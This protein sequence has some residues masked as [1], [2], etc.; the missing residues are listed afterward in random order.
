MEPRFLRFYNQE[1]Q[2]LREMGGE[3]AAEFP[4][5]AGR[6]GLDSFEC[7]DPYVERLLE[8][9]S[10]LSA[11]V[12]LKLDAEFGTFTQ[13]L[14]EIAYP[15]YLS[16]TPSMLVAQFHPDPTEGSLADGYHIPRGTVLRSRLG[17]SDQTP[18]EYR[19]AHDVTLWPLRLT[20]VDYASRVKASMP[21]PPALREAEA[22]LRLR[23][24]TTGGF[25]FSKLKLRELPLFLRAGGERA[26]RLYERLFANVQ[27]VGFGKLGADSTW[28]IVDRHCLQPLGFED[29]HSLLPYGPLSF[30][31]YRLLQEYFAFPERFLFLN[32]LGLE[33]LVGKSGEDTCDI[34]VAFNQA[35]PALENVVGNQD[36][37]LFCTP[38]VNLFHRR[39]DAIHVDHHAAEHHL[40]PDRTRPLDLEVFSV[41]SVAGV[42]SGDGAQQDFRP[43]YSLTDDSTD[44]LGAYFTVRREP[45]V[46]SS[47]QVRQGPRSSYLG[48]EVY[49]SLVD[50]SSAPY[51]SDLSVLLVDTLCTNRDLPMQM[52]LG[53]GNTDFTLTIS[54]PVEGIR[55]LAGPSPPRP[56]L[57]HASGELLWRLVSHLSLNYLSIADG[58]TPQ[59]GAAALRTLLDLYCDRN[60][61]ALK[62]QI[63]GVR[64]VDCRPIVRKLPLEGP[65]VLGRGLEVTLNLDDEAFEGAGTFLFA[66][67]LERF[68]AKYTSINSF[69]ETVLRT[70]QRNEIKRWPMRIGRRHVL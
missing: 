54:A 38:A 36:F 2:F 17:K 52:P 19:T 31:G 25:P 32:L 24:Q 23:L 5:I 12:Q 57:A 21:L 69:T 41:S 42:S 45:R 44:S 29:E 1:L 56:S 47:K 33:A 40:V 15:H 27:A 39:A 58:E 8:G 70:V 51:R 6:L 62:R 22:C 3:F 65:I 9:F 14:L 11:R 48:S 55:C 26:M 37:G 4:K 34:V 16:P 35:D 68:F 18:C 20:A 63:E 61:M 67:V 30:Q 43:F 49:L 64:A 10:F 66:A 59:A 7:A 53:I 60:D 46:M 50:E 28:T 13:H